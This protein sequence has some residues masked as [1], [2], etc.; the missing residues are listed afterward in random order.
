MRLPK[1]TWF[2]QDLLGLT[3]LDVDTG[4]EYGKLTDI[5]KTGGNDVYQVTSPEGKTYLVPSIP[6][7]V[8]E[9]DPE[10]GVVKIRPIKGIFDDED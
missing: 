10:G 9:R 4:K 8:L 6:Q 1:G 2:L 3:V 7:V 5:L